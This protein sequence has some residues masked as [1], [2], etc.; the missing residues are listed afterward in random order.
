M[1]S[2][3]TTNVTHAALTDHR[4]LRR[5]LNAT[6]D[7]ASQQSAPPKIAAW[8]EPPRQFRDRDLALAEI[9]AAISKNQPSL[10]Q[11]GGRLLEALPEIQR[12]GDF[13][14]LSALEGL[15][16]Q[17]GDL[18]SATQ[19]GRRAAELRPGS[20]NAAMNLG[21]VFERSGDAVEAE[22]EFRRA[23]E[24]DISLKPAYQHLAILYGRQRRTQP[25]LD[26]IDRF[27]KWNPQDIMF[28][29]QRAQQT[30]GR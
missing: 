28:R 12:D 17:R 15:S 20:A 22:R 29:L 10:E 1:P 25:M 21:I 19:L 9:L 14:A 3:P 23:I 24:L 7:E 4:I 16:L 2:T 18:V 11:E 30:S 5:P 8:R 13:D 27:L 6:K 26:V